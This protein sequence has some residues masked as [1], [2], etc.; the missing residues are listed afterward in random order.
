MMHCDRCNIDY[1]GGLRYCKWCGQTL[2]ARARSTG[3]IQAC[4]SCF[5]AVQSSWAFC[6]ACGVQLTGQAQE[7]LSATCPRCGAAADP[8]TLNC[9]R[10]GEDLTRGH[11][12]AP[13]SDV[14]ATFAHCPTCGESVDTGSMYCKACGSALYTQT[15]ALSQSALLC[16]VCQSYSPVGS[17]ACR[18]C[19]ALF[20]GAGA[21]AGKEKSS[22]LPDL[23][24]HYPG[25]GEPKADAELESGAH[26]LNF[27]HDKETQVIDS[28]RLGLHP[29]DAPTT[30]IHQ[31]RGA[32]TTVLPGVAGAKAEN[33]GLTS[34]VQRPRI[35]SPVEGEEGS[36]KGGEPASAPVSSG[37][38]PAVESPPPR[39]SAPITRA[40]APS[41]FYFGGGQ[42]GDGLEAKQ[43][44]GESNEAGVGPQSTVI[45]SSET[46][47]PG[48]FESEEK[49]AM[50][51]RIADAPTSRDE[52]SPPKA[53]HPDVM[54]AP[55][56]FGDPEAESDAALSQP[57]TVT[58]ESANAAAQPDAAPMGKPS[59]FKTRS[60]STADFA[61]RADQWKPVP[62]PVAQPV[63]QVAAAAPQK[64]SGAMVV[65]IIVVIL[66]LG[67]TGFALWWY[68]LGGKPVPPVQPPVVETPPVTQPVQPPPT[69]VAPAAPEGMV[70]VA[71]GKYLIGSDDGSDLEKPQHTVELKAYYI[72][73]TE[74]TNADYKKFVDATGHRPPSNWTGGSYPE[75]RES[76]PVTGVTWQD[77]ADYAA[78]AGKRL[79]TEA[80]WEAAARGVDARIYPWGD[81]WREGLANI[82]VRSSADYDASQYPTEIAAAGRFANGAS[83]AGAID[84]IG[85]VWEWTAD[86][87]DLYQGNPVRLE[88]IEIG[89]DRRKIRLEPG[90]TYRI[91][92][93]GAFDGDQQHDSSYRGLIDASKPYP[94]VGFRCVKDAN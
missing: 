49:T 91:F 20:A 33:A 83:Q 64:K 52:L 37:D 39:P 43:A 4:P 30:A 86:E 50:S 79:P 23:S 34:N 63:S 82:G 6:K 41:E 7:P 12:P 8:G 44:T 15:P 2:T 90:I 10:C 24:E 14:T 92:R 31:K 61:E 5:A 66:V 70:L 26:T 59:D 58:L 60:V 36:Q 73:R 87:F 74:V 80:E 46:A 68:V 48:A 28:D 78:W 84:M 32:E 75:G 25:A 69:P 81:Q 35:T 13:Q 40:E 16:T 19:G 67:G 38:L 56:G 42:P 17:T 72:D 89:A 93:G 76:Y 45:F 3:E 47:A 1:P 22:T 53:A 21:S 65:S 71:G 51:G 55:F 85:N 62:E 9:L 57:G 27:V 54:T 11:L 88:E 77:A 29:E 18:V 94:K